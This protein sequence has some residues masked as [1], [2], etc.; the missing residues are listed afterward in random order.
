MLSTN[1]LLAILTERRIKAA[2]LAGF[3]G[4][5]PESADRILL[6]TR[7]LRL[8]EA[9]KLVAIFVAESVTSVAPLSLDMARLLVSHAADT[10]GVTLNPADS[11][12]EALARDFL[13]MA[14]FSADPNFRGSAEEAANLLSGLR[15][16]RKNPESK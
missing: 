2:E 15:H 1:Q 5:T 6:G 3:L 8:E 10:L 14:A 9:R 11:R 12:I 7:H 4:L 13:A 16:A